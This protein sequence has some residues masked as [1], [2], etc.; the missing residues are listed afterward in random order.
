M[1]SPRRGVDFSPAVAD[2]D[3]ST[4]YFTS[5]RA[6]SATGKKN[7]NITGV[8]NND[9]FIVKKDNKGKWDKP[10]P[11]TA[12]I[13]T[14][15]DEGACSFSPDGR[16]MYFTQCRTMKG[17]TLGAEIYFSQRAGGEWTAAQKV[18]LVADSSI[19][20]AHPAMSPDGEYLYYVSDMP[21]GFGGKDIWRSKKISD[22]EWGAPENLGN[23]INTAG[24]EM[25]PAFGYDRAFYF[26]SNGLPGLGG[27]DIF[28]ATLISQKDEPLLWQTENM[29]APINSEG[30]DFGISFLGKENKGYLSSNRKEPR[31]YDKIY[32]FEV[33]VL[34]FAIEG[35]VRDYNNDIISDAVVRIVGDDGTNIK[36]R[37]KKD[38][39]YR[40]QLE[41]NVNYVMQASARGFLNEKGS[42]STQNLRKTQIF[43]QDFRLP[44][45]GKPIPIDNIFYEFGSYVLTPSSEEALM[46]TVKMLEDNPNITVEIGAHTDMVGTDEF[47]QALSTRRAESVVNFLIKQGIAPDRLVARGYGESKPVVVDAP[48][49]EKYVFLT[50]GDVLDEEFINKLPEKD[51]ETANQINRRTEFVVLKTTYKMR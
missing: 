12:E 30:D 34:A 44:A 49:A 19:S 24:D 2:A 15:F 29:L 14:E 16:T 33:P 39:A 45:A 31:G 5:S 42:L 18:V 26:S 21:D 51:H 25:F 10:E 32:R 3:G 37:V 13:N 40:F 36:I 50:E 27:L 11:L 6:N 7:S 41:K 8:R 28:R 47:N 23:S 48:L 20:V 43:K 17:E 9:I 22:S 35:K 38:G 1:N 4:I 46:G